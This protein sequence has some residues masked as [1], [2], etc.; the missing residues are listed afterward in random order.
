MEV[1]WIITIIKRLS[2]FTHEVQQKFLA[3]NAERRL[4]ELSYNNAF[5]SAVAIVII[6]TV[7]FTVIE[8]LRLILIHRYHLESEID[9]QTDLS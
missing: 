9:D 1:I 3:D 6:F 7:C 2:N 4:M 5:R 8:I